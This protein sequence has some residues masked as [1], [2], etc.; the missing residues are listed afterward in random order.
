MSRTP[1]SENWS[2]ANWPTLKVAAQLTGFDACLYCLGVSAVGMPEPEYR[3]ITYD[4]TLAAANVLAKRDNAF[5]R[6]GLAELGSA[7]P[8][9][10]LSGT[11]RGVGANLHDFS[12]LGGP[13]EFESEDRFRVAPTRNIP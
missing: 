5:F 12:R 10:R 1:S 9:P 8:F 2:I 3:R 4:V 6:R 7:A 11:V 13:G